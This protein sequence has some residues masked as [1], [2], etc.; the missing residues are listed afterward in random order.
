M[1]QLGTPPERRAAVDR[2]AAAL[3][4]EL[5]ASLVTAGRL[6]VPGA[7]DPLV[8]RSSPGTPGRGAGAP[9]AQAG[10]PGTR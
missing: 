10:L 8:P 3:P 5:R 9:R 4:A 1:G 7:A 6:S 2:I